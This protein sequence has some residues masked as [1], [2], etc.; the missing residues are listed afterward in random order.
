MEFVFFKREIFLEFLKT[1]ISN[2]VVLSTPKM[3]LENYPFRWENE[4]L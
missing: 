4:H 3:A 2:V 1:T